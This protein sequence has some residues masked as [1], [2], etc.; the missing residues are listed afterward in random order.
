M[1]KLSVSYLSTIVKYGY[2]PSLKSTEQGFMEIADWGFHNIELEGLGPA[3]SELMC[4]RAPEIKKMLDDLGLHC[5]NFCAVDAN[6]THPN[7]RLRRRAMRTVENVC[8]AADTVGAETL[9]LA[10]YP[11]HVNYPNGLPYK[12]GRA[13]RFDDCIIARIPRGYSFARDWGVLVRSCRAI[14]DL[15]ARHDRTVI[16]EPRVGEMICSSDS[17]LRLLEDVGRANFKANFDTA[18]FAKQREVI[19]ITLEKLRGHYANIHVADY[20]GRALDHLPCGRGIVDW[21]GFVEGLK[22]HG[23][24]GYLGIDTSRAKTMHADVSASAEFLMDLGRRVGL[25]I[26]R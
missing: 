21:N 23:Y 18:H 12:V 24:S 25:A 20:N 14:A 8:E 26:V 6:L 10:S 11:P 17:M 7:P 16:M 22:R 4:R 3:H 9:H 5:H 15:S 13:Y 1:I 19:P 2:P